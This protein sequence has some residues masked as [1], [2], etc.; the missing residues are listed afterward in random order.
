MENQYNPYQNS[1]LQ[2]TNTNPTSNYYQP[3]YY[4][5]PIIVPQVIN[6]QPNY[7]MNY[8]L[9]Q[10]DNQMREITKLKEIIDELKKENEKLKLTHEVIIKN[11]EVSNNFVDNSIEKFQEQDVINNDFSEK[12]KVINNRI[13][14]AYKKINKITKYQE[15]QE[16]D[17][18]SEDNKNINKKKS[19]KTKSEKT[20]ILNTEK[21]LEHN[22]DIKNTKDFSIIKPQSALP[23]STFFNL[24]ETIMNEPQD[25]S[26]K[27]NDLIDSDDEYDMNV[28]VYTNIDDVKNKVDDETNKDIINI[29]IEIKSIQDLIKLGKEHKIN[30]VNKTNESNSKI[31][32]EINKTNN[33]NNNFMFFKPYMTNTPPMFLTPF[34]Q[35]NM[36]FNP[37]LSKIKEKEISDSDNEEYNYELV[38][39]KLNNSKEDNNEQIFNIFIKNK[40]LSK[41]TKN[42]N[43][44]I[45]DKT[46][47]IS[48]FY[49]YGGKKY[50]IDME[51]IV[52]L[53]EP[54]TKLNNTIGMTDIKLHIL[55][56]ILYYIQ[57]FEKTTSDMLHT[58]IE[59]PPGVGKSKL[60]RIL[61]LI[62][63]ALGVIPSKRFKRVRRTD[64]IGK[65]LGHTAHKTQEVIDEAEGGV[66]FIDEA[67]SLGSG[68][69]DRDSFAKEC[70]DT[71]NMNLTEKK[72]NLIVIVAGYTEQLDKAFFS[73]NEGLR[74]RF[75]FRFT[76]K[77]YNE[78]ELTQIFYCKIKKLGWKLDTKLSQDY[79]EYFFKTNK[80]DLN[81]FGGDIETIILN[82]KMT[83]AKRIMGSPYY[84]KK[85]ISKEDFNS[86]YERFKLNKNN[87]EELSDSVKHL[88]M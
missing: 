33:F 14:N 87:K 85:I 54:L 66:L 58:S 77:G 47:E 29:N 8:L 81:N 25:T 22:K 44:K 69:E 79:L 37:Q 60:G 51:K 30:D 53:I 12:L 15:Q 27:T 75:P 52:N 32:P 1:Y 43:E 74:R 34:T 61:A 50:N 20:L 42:K 59:G 73:M 49:N 68:N 36:Q 86:A 76:I 72:K 9:I 5:P 31:N 78:E 4:Q 35:Q 2:N 16:I 48:K 46:N 19:S 65:Y 7:H 18:D 82:C 45:I 11:S 41:N 56:M 67:Y 38:N 21:P 6:S 70:I 28:D 80:N 10:L 57:G 88:Y 3:P 71:I 17:I 84:Y 55:D 40:Y 23:M 26:K 39:N 24:L 63:H 64:L 13:N 83:H 62:Y